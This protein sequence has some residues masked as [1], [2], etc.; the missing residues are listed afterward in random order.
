VKRCAQHYP[1]LA[2]VCSRCAKV[3]KRKKVYLTACAT[4]GQAPVC[5]D[6]RFVLQRTRSHKRANPAT[7]APPDKSHRGKWGCAWCADLA[8]RRPEDGTPCRCGGV[9]VPD[10]VTLADI[11]RQ[12]R[13]DRRALP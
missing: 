8:H 7:D 5:D 1:L 13:A 10:V 6:C 4:K 12:P 2:F 9:Y 11:F 3:A